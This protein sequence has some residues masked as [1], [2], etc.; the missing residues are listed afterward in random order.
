[1]YYVNDEANFYY[2]GVL[3]GY[4]NFCFTFIFVNNSPGS[5]TQH[6]TYPKCNLTTKSHVHV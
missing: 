3:L 6:V 2:D 5:N 1:M 4:V